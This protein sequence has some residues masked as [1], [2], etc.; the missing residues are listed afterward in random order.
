M[1]SAPTA[2]P[3]APSSSKQKLG[4]Y[5][6]YRSIG[7]PKY[8]VAPMVDQSELAWRMLSRSPLSPSLAGPPSEPTPEVP[9]KRHVGGATLVYTPM[10]HAKVFSSSKQVSKGG[11]GQFDLSHEEEGSLDDIGDLGISDRP[12]F[13]QFC[14]NDPEVLLAAAKKVEH[15]CDAVDINL[16]VR[17]HTEL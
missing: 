2:G 5:D 17:S 8:V 3:S 4:G 1:S 13:V 6:F 14:A 9:Y 16:S 10:I 11:D 15:R 12:L 7:S